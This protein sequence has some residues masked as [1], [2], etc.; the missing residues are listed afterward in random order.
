MIQVQ[1]MKIK[2]DVNIKFPDRDAVEEQQ[3]PHDIVNGDDA[4]AVDGNVASE[5]IIYEDGTEPIRAGDIIRITGRLENCQAAQQ[6]LI[7]LIPITKEMHVAFDLHRSIIGQKGRDVREL[8]QRYDVHIELSPQDQQLD[9]IKITGAPQNIED[10][11]VAIEDRVKDLELDRKDRELRAFELTFEVDPEW[12]PKIIGRRGA[13][14]NKI[15]GDHGVQIIFPKKE[16]EVDNVIKIQGY[17]EAAHA[18]KA[19][20]LKI[21]GE[22][23]DLTK[24]VVEIDSRVHA[25]IIGQRG[26]GIRKIMDD[27]KVE[28]KFPRDA[29]RDEN[30]NA[31]TIIGSEDAVSDAKDHLLNME[32]EYLQDVVDM[33][34]APQS[35]NDFSAVLETA[36]SYNRGGDGKKEGFV[37]Q[38]APWE[39]KNKKAPNTASHEDFP[40]FGI[41]SV[42]R[43]T[44]ITSAWGQRR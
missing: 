22:L 33:A 15:R 17:E 16:E 32:E 40:D 34:P 42:V 6:A 5:P 9:I 13:V 21:V 12:H 25:R 41:P 35:S 8:M 28:I 31:V 27:F 18:A 4:G 14:I 10:A 44:P 19:D 7:D 11:I 29:E 3:Q 20:I 38:G 24:E 39:K 23:S 2:F 36:F 26:R 43:E 30:P 1:D 37:V